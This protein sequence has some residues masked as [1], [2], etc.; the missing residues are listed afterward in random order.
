MPT[1]S[2]NQTTPL[3]IKGT[4]VS[5]YNQ[6]TKDGLIEYS[7]DK[8]I[9]GATALVITSSVSGITIYDKAVATD[10]IAGFA[11]FNK[12]SNIFPA[13]TPVSIAYNGSFMYMEAGDIIDAGSPL[14]IDPTGDL[15]IPFATPGNTIIGIAQADAALGDIVP[16]L[17]EIKTTA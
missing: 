10:P 5:G 2:L 17:I 12:I 16:V 15:V 6:N 13:S 7:S 4:D 11:R 3:A 1:F 9:Y 14:E 8:L